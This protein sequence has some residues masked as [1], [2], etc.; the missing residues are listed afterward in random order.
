[1]HTKEWQCCW[2]WFSLTPGTT[3]A[4]FATSPPF[5]LSSAFSEACC[6]RM[7]FPSS[8]GC[9]HVKLED[10]SFCLPLT[11]LFP[12]PASSLPNSLIALFRVIYTIT[13]KARKQKAGIL[14]IELKHVTSVRCMSEWNRQLLNLPLFHSCANTNPVRLQQVYCSGSGHTLFAML[15]GELQKQNGPQPPMDIA[16]P[17]LSS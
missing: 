16:V 9:K 11:P 2:L 4:R 17:F 13:G 8:P 7:L 12:N 10:P 14:L 5:P 6:F 1:M 3:K 15:L